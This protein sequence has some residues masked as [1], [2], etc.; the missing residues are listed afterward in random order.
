MIGLRKY[1]K[2]MFTFER[3]CWRYKLFLSLMGCWPPLYAKRQIF[4]RLFV[5]ICLISL[6]LIQVI[7]FQV[8]A[9][10]TSAN[11]LDKIV[12]I[13]TY[14][15]PVLGMDTPY[16][17][18]Y[19]NI[20]KTMYFYNHCIADWE[21]LENEEEPL[22]SLSGFLLLFVSLK[23]V[24]LDIISPL[25]ETRPRQSMIPVELFFIDKNKYFF[26]ECFIIFMTGF[27][28]GCVTIMS[29]NILF[30]GV[31]HGCALFEYVG[32]KLEHLI[33]ENEFN[34]EAPISKIYEKIRQR[35][36]S[37]INLHKRA[38]EYMD[39][40]NSIS[41]YF[42]FIAMIF[43]VLVIGVDFFIL[44]TTTD[45]FQSK[46]KLIL[47]IIYIPGSVMVIYL[48]CKMGQKVLDSSENVL[49]KAR[50][51]PWYLLPPNMQ[52]AAMLIMIR[53]KKPCY[54]TIG[55]IFISSHQFFTSIVR[56]AM[57]YATMAHSFR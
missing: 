10:F 46:N 7:V 57:S 48:T 42:F 5:N 11:E 32:Y 26:L 44:Q 31:Q 51:V 4:K 17:A 45:I 25:N 13:M 19:F 2:R 22:Y 54:L 47:L 49:E 43:E 40:I 56:T 53:S 3:L 16:F 15:L 14:L 23:P 39:C 28:T 18:V 37:N 12:E 30:F 20:E 21:K 8:F 52:K 35:I 6:I 50:M 38:L 33:D 34:Q 1:I 29:L 9:L 24:Y 41:S 55:K 27:V 36:V